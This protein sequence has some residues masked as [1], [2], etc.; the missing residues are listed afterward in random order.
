MKKHRQALFT[1]ED[2]ALITNMVTLTDEDTEE[3]DDASWVD[4]EDVEHDGDIAY[5][6]KESAEK[7]KISLCDNAYIHG[8]KFDQDLRPAMIGMYMN[9]RNEKTS[10]KFK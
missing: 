7:L 3:I 8:Q 6:K 10:T 1:V 2:L 4:D 9:L 5:M